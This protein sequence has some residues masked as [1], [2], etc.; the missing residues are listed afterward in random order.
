MH[1]ARKMT[2][3]REM[4][5]AKH[6]ETSPNE[7]S[8]RASLT[9]QQSYH[10]GLK[11]HF[12]GQTFYCSVEKLTSGF[13]VLATDTNTPEVTKTTVSTNLLESL[14]IIAHLGVNTVGKN[15]EVLAIGD[16][17]LPVQEPCRNLKLSGV[18]DD[19][20]NTLKLIRVELTGA[21]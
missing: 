2:K 12:K 10:D 6:I 14:Q 11:Q 7:A 19:G 13:C 15:L 9:H 3:I 17:P 1:I 8:S 5:H 20:D 4:N 18:L 16:I 21:M